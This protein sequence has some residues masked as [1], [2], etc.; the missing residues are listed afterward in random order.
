MRGLKAR[1]L[2]V[3]FGAVT[4]VGFLCILVVGPPSSHVGAFDREDWTGQV[5]EGS[6]S[7]VVVFEF[8]NSPTATWNGADRQAFRDGALSWNE[9]VRHNGVPYVTV[10]EFTGRGPAP[11]S[12]ERV[13]PAEGNSTNC[14]TRTIRVGSTVRLDGTA[15][16]EVGHALGL[17]HSGS[18]EGW[19][20]GGSLVVGTTG[21]PP[22]MFYCNVS[23]RHTRPSVD[24]QA[25]LNAFHLF[26]DF[27]LPLNGASP[28][29][30]FEGS[31]LDQAAFWGVDGYAFS[32][33]ARYAIVSDP[34]TVGTRVRWTTPSAR[35][36]LKF[37]YRAGT[38]SQ[39][40]YRLHLRSVTYPAGPTTW[41]GCSDPTQYSNN[42]NYSSPTL[43]TWSLKLSGTI[44]V[45]SGWSTT[46]WQYA[47]CAIGPCTTYEGLDV[48]VQFDALGSTGG[49]MHLDRVWIN[50]TN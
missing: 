21:K 10:E 8:V 43:G 45:P 1:P 2:V 34:N 36:A 5:C 4:V 48:Q 9:V 40:R 14:V 13:S 11:W 30:G 29:R 37:R 26:D 17:D 6:Q 50:S 42:H 12:V 38:A 22:L 28:D 15:A 46:T 41:P 25:A 19:I 44:T 24:D 3:G 16:H 23:T 33:G 27:N 7:D 47:S 49:S 18:A 39:L 32:S 31:G 35:A 20:D